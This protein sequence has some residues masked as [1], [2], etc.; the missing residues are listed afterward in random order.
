[1]SRV[2]HHINKGEHGCLDELLGR[3]QML[4]A[5]QILGGSGLRIE[6]V[7]HILGDPYLPHLLIPCLC[8]VTTPESC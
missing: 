8:N 4:P 6:T 5:V 1:M 3:M 7:S 2:R